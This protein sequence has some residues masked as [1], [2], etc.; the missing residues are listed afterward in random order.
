MVGKDGA[1]E[2]KKS[3]ARYIQVLTKLFKLVPNTYLLLATRDLKLLS[4]P[5]SIRNTGLQGQKTVK[6]KDI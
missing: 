3:V 4:R 1:R 6:D 2:T 5:S